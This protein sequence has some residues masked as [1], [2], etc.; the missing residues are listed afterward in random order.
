MIHCCTFL[1]THVMLI[2]VMY[3]IMLDGNIL[4]TVFDLDKG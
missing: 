1:F 3:D 2:K 4:G